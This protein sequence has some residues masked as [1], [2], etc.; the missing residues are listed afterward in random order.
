MKSLNQILGSAFVAAT[1]FLASCTSEPC[2]NVVCVNSGVATASTDG[3][4]C[5]CACTGGYEG[6]SCQTAG[7]IK[8]NGTYNAS[9][10]VGTSTF[11]SSIT[12]VA[13]TTGATT[14]N[15][16]KFGNYNCALTGGG[17]SKITVPFTISSSNTSNITFNSTDGSI[18]GYKITGS[19]S[20]SGTTISGTYVAT[21]GTP[22]TT[23]NVTFTWTKI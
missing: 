6:D 23:D 20:K 3:K 4:S 15:V 1:L 2:K 10:K 19:G 5:A 7:N 16:E 8:F 22:A 17:T 21:Y 11:T 18:C 9:E 13:V 14:V 12:L